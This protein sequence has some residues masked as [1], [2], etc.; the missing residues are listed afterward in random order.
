MHYLHYFSG[1]DTVDTVDILYEGW[2]TGKWPCKRLLAQSFG[3][4]VL[5]R[6][7]LVSLISR[8]ASSYQEQLQIKP[9]S[10]Q[11][12]C[13]FTLKS[14]LA[15]SFNGG[16]V[17]GSQLMS[18]LLHTAEKQR[19]TLGYCWHVALCTR[20]IEYAMNGLSVNATRGGEM[21]SLWE[22]HKKH[23]GYFLFQ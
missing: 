3:D 22:T 10:N 16:F 4:E 8:S 13:C 14:Y 17:A 5:M 21:L 6:C 1:K 2:N 12:N 11:C 23:F 20:P 7:G 19:G 9:A 15:D 18:S